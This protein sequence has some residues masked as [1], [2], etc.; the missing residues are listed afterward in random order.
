MPY[1]IKFAGILNPVLSSFLS[2]KFEVLR[3]YVIFPN[4]QGGT[5]LA[6]ELSQPFPSNPSYPCQVQS[7]AK[8]TT[9]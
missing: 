1:N 6:S 5:D 2:E 9:I 3:G 4:C 7:L 8:E